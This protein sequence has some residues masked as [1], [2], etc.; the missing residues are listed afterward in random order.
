MQIATKI[1]LT[2]LLLSGT[3]FY[4]LFEKGKFEK[5]ISGPYQLVLKELPAFNL[6]DVYSGE[7][8]SKE[9][10]LAQAGQSGI[11][12]HFWG[13]W[14][15]PC[16]AELPEFLQ[17]VKEMDREGVSF[18]FLAVNDEVKKVRRFMKRF[19]KELPENVKILIDPS[20][21]TMAIFGTARVPETYLFTKSGQHVN[22][23]VG[24]QN[25]TLPDYKSRTR[26]LLGI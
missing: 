3:L 16:E 9:V 19:E 22:K 10:I 24:P 26:L 13:T 18:V 23:F 12:V 11:F 25:W 20:G 7:M 17:F 21:E 2:S 8:V 5:F 1:F 14:C 4:G 6:L 15:A